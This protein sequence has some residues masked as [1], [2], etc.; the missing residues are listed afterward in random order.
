MQ[1]E[2]I[3]FVVQLKNSWL[4][5][6]QGYGKHSNNEGI[7]EHPHEKT[8]V[9]LGRHLVNK[10]VELGAC[11]LSSNFFDCETKNVTDNGP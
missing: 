11:A 10:I 8:M 5:C 2:K 6:E 4:N 9:T 1:K 3:M 7:Q